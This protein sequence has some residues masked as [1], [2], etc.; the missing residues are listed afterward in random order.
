[1]KSKLPTCKQ[2][3]SNLCQSIRSFYAQEIDHPPKNIICKLFSQYI[4]IV[5]DDALTPLEQSLQELGEEELI[6]ELRSEVNSIFR[7]KLAKIIE[8]TLNIKVEE[9]LSNVTVASNKLGTLVVLSQA[10]L[11]RKSKSP[12]KAR[13]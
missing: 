7:P 11:V 13:Q 6:I 12:L 4:A 9:I 8:E 3:E 5:A 10:P 1:M 2:L